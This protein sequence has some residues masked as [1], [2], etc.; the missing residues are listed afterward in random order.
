[1]FSQFVDRYATDAYGPHI[2]TTAAIDR[3]GQVGELSALDIN[4]PFGDGIDAAQVRESLERNR[5]TALAITPHLYTRVFQRG[6]FTNPDPKIRRQA[7]D[8]SKRAVEAAHQLGAAYVKFWPGQ[9]GFDY[10]FQVDYE[11]VWEDEVRGIEE[12]AA[13]DPAMQFAIEYKFKEPR[14]HMLLNTAAR[15]L[16]AIEEMRVDNV[17]IVLDLGHSLLGKETPA[18]ALGLVARR[19]KLVSVELND[20]WREWDDDLTVGSVHLI[21]SLEFLDALRRLPFDGVWMLDQFPFRED[22]VKAAKASI[23]TLRAMNRLLDRMDRSQ[24]DLARQEQD[25]VAAQRLILDLLLDR[26]GGE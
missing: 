21:E 17:G 10:P 3:A 23:A 15:T 14:T 5:L 20:N 8:L 1:M 2:S 7:I 26:E 13:S 22:P 18:E 6:S 12:V 4:F 24:L 25:A 19:G 16:L 11:R 9:D